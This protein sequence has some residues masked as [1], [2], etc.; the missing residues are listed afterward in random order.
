MKRLFL[1]FSL[2]LLTI[3]VWSV[4]KS[5]NYLNQITYGT[6][7]ECVKSLIGDYSSK[8]VVPNE[9]H[10]Y[11][12]IYVLCRY[13]STVTTDTYYITF[14]NDKVVE[15]GITDRAT[16]EYIMIP[17]DVQ[18]SE[19][20]DNI[21]NARMWQLNGHQQGDKRVS[22]NSPNENN[23]IETIIPQM[24]E[25]NDKVFLVNKSPYT[26][27]KAVIVSASNHQLVLGSCG[28]VAPG[29]QVELAEFSDNGLSKWRGIP[30]D[31]KIKGYT[32]SLTLI[33]DD[34]I[35][36]EKITYDF[37]VHMYEENHDLYISAQIIK[38]DRKTDILDF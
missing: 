29:A 1:T 3:C 12:C 27:I 34:L 28:L 10:S 5:C 37:K 15:R 17:F 23:V 35:N 13:N 22:S 36:S 26:I 9:P 8:K 11:K 6:T 24:L 20:L 21:E 18:F 38:N 31:I 4:K 25:I 30:I 16:T 7:Y 19:A 32:E 2:L 14:E 33:D